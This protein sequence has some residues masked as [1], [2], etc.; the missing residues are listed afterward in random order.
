MLESMKARRQ[1]RGA[2]RRNRPARNSRRKKA[3]VAQLDR[4]QASDA[5]CRW[6]ESNR[7]HQRKRIP[8]KW[9]TLSLFYRLDSSASLGERLANL[10]SPVDC[11]RAALYG[12][13]QSDAPKQ[14]YPCEG[15]YAC[16]IFLSIG[17]ECELG[18]QAWQSPEWKY[19]ITPVGLPHSANA[20]FAMTCKWRAILAL[21]CTEVG[22]P[23]RQP[24]KLAR[25][26]SP[27]LR[28]Q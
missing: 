4:A 2:G 27:P 3:L 5:W 1:K 15:G 26:G 9:G 24:R 18:S 7:M 12:R 17:F 6:F 23:R 14:A 22:L 16:F 11:L 20:P 8:V 10:N 19:V 28:S 21:T 25:G 13:I